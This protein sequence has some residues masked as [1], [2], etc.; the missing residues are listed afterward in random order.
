[1]THDAAAALLLVILVVINFGL[2]RS[3]STSL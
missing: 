3:P 1:M 2:S